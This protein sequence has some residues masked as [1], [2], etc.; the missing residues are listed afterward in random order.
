MT[1]QLVAGILLWSVINMSTTALADVVEIEP[2]QDNTLYEDA[3]GGLSNGAGDHFF[4]GLIRTG[5]ERRGLIAFDIAAAVPAG[6]TVNSVILTLFVSLARAPVPNVELRTVDSSWGEGTSDALEPGGRGAAATTDDATWVHRFF[7]TVDW[8][9]PGGDFADAS[10]AVTAVA[11]FGSYTWGS[12]PAMEQDVQGWLDTPAS[13]FGWL[14]KAANGSANQ[15]AKRF[16]SRE[17]PTAS[18]RPRLTVDFTPPPV[19]PQFRRGDANDDGTV[20]IAD[21]SRLLDVLF[22]GNTELLCVDAADSNDDGALDISDVVTT[23][24]V[25]FREGVNIPD[26]G[27]NVCGADPTDDELDCAEYNSSC[28]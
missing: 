15:T 17:N 14:L 4:V 3:N 25:L 27:P 11:S 20:N 24:L 7:N 21:A 18:N 2:S 8:T 28:G 9:T 13:N 12:T 1:K 26:P 22:V 5:P 6:S 16:D 10:S 23:L 19:P